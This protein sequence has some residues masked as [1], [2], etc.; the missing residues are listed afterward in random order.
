MLTIIH[1]KKDLCVTEKER[2]LTEFFNGRWVRFGYRFLYHCFSTVIPL[3]F[4]HS[5]IESEK[6]GVLE[7]FFPKI[8]FDGNIKSNKVPVLLLSLLHS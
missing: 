2:I 3:F 5:I 7:I 4:A 6:L 1:G 8:T